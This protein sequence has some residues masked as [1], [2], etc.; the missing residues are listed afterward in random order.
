MRPDRPW[1]ESWIGATDLNGNAFTRAEWLLQVVTYARFQ[2]ARDRV[3]LVLTDLATRDALR[4]LV[5]ALVTRF[6]PERLTEPSQ[7]SVDATPTRGP[8]DRT[9]VPV[10]RRTGALRA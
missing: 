4:V 7:R 9:P 6:A 1:P 2:G 10:R 3:A 5:A 8:C